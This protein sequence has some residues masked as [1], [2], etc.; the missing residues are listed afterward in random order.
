MTHSITHS[1]RSFS[2]V[3][4]AVIATELGVL[5]GESEERVGLDTLPTDGILVIG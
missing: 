2:D 5:Y 4:L 3:L 1:K